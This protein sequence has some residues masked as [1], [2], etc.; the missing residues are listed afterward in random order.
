MEFCPHHPSAPSLENKGFGVFCHQRQPRHCCFAWGLQ[1]AYLAYVTLKWR[2]LA[3]SGRN[4][5]AK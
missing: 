5:S 2:A 1:L 4:S 3:K